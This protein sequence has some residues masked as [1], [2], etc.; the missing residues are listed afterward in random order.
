MRRRRRSETA[1]IS[2]REN[3]SLSTIGRLYATIR[4]L[5][6]YLLALR[7]SFV[8]TL[9]KFASSKTIILLIRREGRLYVAII[10]AGK[11]NSFVITTVHQFNQRF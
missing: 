1:E 9:C 4:Q 7:I 3:T 8:A 11:T 2:D 10:I 5:D 6:R